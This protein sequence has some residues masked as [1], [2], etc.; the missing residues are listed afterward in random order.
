[1]NGPCHLGK[2]FIKL[3]LRCQLWTLPATLAIKQ[4]KFTSPN[5]DAVEL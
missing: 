2:K 3:E 5:R 4:L 1:M